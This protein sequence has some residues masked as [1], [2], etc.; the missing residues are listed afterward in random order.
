MNHH[1]GNT[2]NTQAFIEAINPYYAWY[3]F[4]ENS[5]TDIW[6]S[7]WCSDPVTRMSQIAN[8]LGTKYC[9][10]R[11]ERLCLGFSAETHKDYL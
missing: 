1:G 3:N 8:T 2:S 4:H 10:R 7:G 6:A 9:F 5:R 11:I